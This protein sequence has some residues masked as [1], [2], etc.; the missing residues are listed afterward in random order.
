V[1]VGGRSACDCTSPPLPYPPNVHKHVMLQD[2]GGGAPD[3]EPQ[4]LNCR[5]MGE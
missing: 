1:A 2:E 3:S 4:S 5:Q